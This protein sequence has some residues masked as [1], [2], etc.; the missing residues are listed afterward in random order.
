MALWMAT[1]RL[2][3]ARAIDEAEPLGE[4]PRQILGTS[5]T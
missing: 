2:L 1:H 5:G 4:V 3:L